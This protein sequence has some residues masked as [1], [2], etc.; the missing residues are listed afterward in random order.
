MFFTR[1][2]ASTQVTLSFKTQAPARSNITTLS[3]AT[4]S[5]I[6]AHLHWQRF[7][8][9]ITPATAT[10]D[11]HYLIALATLG[12]ATEIEMILSLL[13]RPRWPRQ[14]SSDSHVLLLRVAVASTIPLNFANGNTGDVSWFICCHNLLYFSVECRSL[15]CHSAQCHGASYIVLNGPLAIF[16]VSR[17]SGKGNDR[18]R[19]GVA[20]H[21]HFADLGR[22]FQQPLT[23]ILRSF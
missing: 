20:A 18:V 1:N 6:K 12:D 11:S 10:R 9:S 16:V 2:Q 8:S 4:F 13:R 21:L 22:C 7:Y 19:L 15:E 3:R 5:R 23:I 17:T 14:I